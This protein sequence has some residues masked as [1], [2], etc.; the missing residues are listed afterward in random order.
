MSFDVSLPAILGYFAAMQFNQNNVT[1]E[2]SPLTS[3][4]EYKVGQDLCKMLGFQVASGDNQGDNQGKIVGWGHITCGGSIANL[5]SMWVARNLKY[6]PLSLKWAMEADRRLRFVR[7]TFGTTL[8]TGEKKNFYSCSP[9]ELLNLT[10]TEIAAIPGRL[11]AQYNISP[12]ALGDILQ[13]FSIQT[14]GKQ[15]LDAQ[16]KITEPPQYLIS[17]ANHYSWPK[18]A[19]IT[20]IGRE[21]MI[22]LGIDEDARLDIKKLEK[23]LE[24]HLRKKQSL[25]AVVVIIG[26][27]EHGSVDPLDKVVALRDVWQR[28]KGLSFMIHADAAWGGY[29]ASKKKARGEWKVPPEPEYGFSLPLSYH[30]NEQMSNL[31]H[32]D[33]I[34]IDP[35]KSGYCPYPAGAICYR[36][37]RHRFLTTWDS[38]YLS[39]NDYSMG[40]YGVEGSKPGAA[41][42]GVWLSLESMTVPGYAD[43][44]GIAMLTGAK[45]YALW[46][47]T[48]LDSRSLVVTPFNR[49]PSEKSGQSPEEIKKERVFIRERIAEA[50][51]SELKEDK[52]ALD[53][54]G[55]L[56][57]DLMIN[58]FACNFHID[59]KVNTDVVEASFL[60]HRLYKRLSVTTM[61]DQLNQKPIIIMAT[62][63]SQNKYGKALT[64]FKKRMGLEGEEDLYALSNVSMSPWPTTSEFLKSIVDEFKLVAEE[65]IK[66]CLVRAV[67]KKSIHSFVLLGTSDLYLVYMGSFNVSNY[68]RQVILS[69]KLDEEV[70]EKLNSIREQNDKS[71]FTFHTSEEVTFT[72]LLKKNEWKGNIFKGV[73]KDYGTASIS[74]PSLSNV[75]IRDFKV[76]LHRSLHRDKIGADYPKKMPFY[77]FGTS[78]E[79]HMDHLLENAPNVHLTASKVCLDPPPTGDSLFG[80]WVV[81]ENMQED[82]M[83]PFTAS[84]PPTLFPPSKEFKVTIYEHDAPKDPES[85]IP[86]SIITSQKGTSGTLTLSDKQGDLFIDYT[87]LNLDAA[88]DIYIS[89]DKQSDID[90]VAEEIAWL[91]K[92]E[93]ITWDD[94]V[95]NAIYAQCPRAKKLTVQLGQ[96]GYPN[97]PKAV[98]SRFLGP[99][100][101]VGQSLPQKLDLTGA[102]KALLLPE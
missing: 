51:N 72:E 91:F 25:Y 34:T 54:L 86:S 81:L 52:K 31:R 87:W 40:I 60:N 56:G 95:V 27:T 15:K 74:T 73:P 38:P 22:E 26:T 35:H 50:K 6:Y 46:A 37:G 48:T 4:I 2:A 64:T 61:N 99:E 89:G 42:V 8:C 65:E 29:F 28:E 94:N 68:R 88:A 98:L 69:A 67:E 21:N 44:L 82:I 47:T 5:E 9:W 36:D 1:P 59:G 96:L 41:P 10:P 71:S 84:H 75:S 12:F 39:S 18:G 19:A 83:H 58:A 24:E 55:M 17:C 101:S 43:L 76:L 32:A 77:L 53:L 97:L 33:S 11:T 102:M 45:M 70:M 80:K 66:T 20:G 63:F 90:Q 7:E 3:M 85:P 93:K 13:Q 16:F 78:K 62:N 49:L 57:S 100:G 14:V 92:Q 79:M 23:E 30:T